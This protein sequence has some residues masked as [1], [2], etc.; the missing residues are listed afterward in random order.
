MTLG[1]E[2]SSGAAMDALAGDGGGEPL[3]LV[4]KVIFL[5]RVP[6]LAGSTVEELD[7][8]GQEVGRLVGVQS[9]TQLEAALAGH[10]GARCDG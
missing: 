8:G 7:A 10:T 4:Q 2:N 5:K 1:G 9:A 3:D 6:L